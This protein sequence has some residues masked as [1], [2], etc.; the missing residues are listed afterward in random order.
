MSNSTTTK[1]IGVFTSG[2]DSQG[3]NAA[4]RAVVRTGSTQGAESTP[5][6]RATRAW[7]KAGATSAR[8][9]GSTW[10]ASCIAR[11]HDHRLRALEGF[12]TREGRRR[13]A[14]NLLDNGIDG[15]V[16]IGGDGSLTGANLF[17]QEWPELLAELVAAG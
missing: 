8:S 6:T 14:Y 5:S 15:L 2:G 9:A 13:A 10:A 17:R 16:A 1:R 4:V 3:M 11:R 12:R 7:W